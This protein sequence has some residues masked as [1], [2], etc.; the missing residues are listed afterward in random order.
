MAR[1]NRSLLARAVQ[2]L[3]KEAGGRQFLDLGTGARCGSPTKA[4]T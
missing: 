4:A 2:Y 3:V 1:A